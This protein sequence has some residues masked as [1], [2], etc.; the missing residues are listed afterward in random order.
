MQTTT[1]ALALLLTCLFLVVSVFPRSP[2]NPERIALEGS[3]H[4]QNIQLFYR[5]QLFATLGQILSW[6]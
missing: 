4:L 3:F 6:H 2:Q 1:L 5:Y